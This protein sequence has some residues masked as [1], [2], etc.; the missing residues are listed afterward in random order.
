MEGKIAIDEQSDQM[1]EMTFSKPKKQAKK[2]IKD[3]TERISAPS[4]LKDDVR[5]SGVCGKCRKR[6]TAVP[7]INGVPQCPDC[8]HV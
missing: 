3:F 8:D 7:V 1:G 5:A 6:F 4:A 2:E